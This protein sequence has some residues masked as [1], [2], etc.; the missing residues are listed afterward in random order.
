MNVRHIIQ[1]W[2]LSI[3]NDEQS[4]E[5]M[6]ERAKICLPC[7]HSKVM[8]IGTWIKGEYEEINDMGCE[9]CGCPLNQK[10]RVADESCPLNK[11]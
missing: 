11:W 5:L 10:L 9:K 3:M 4:T 6:K 7:E 8:P 1:G 2:W